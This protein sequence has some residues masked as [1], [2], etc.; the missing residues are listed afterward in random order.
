MN[1]QPNIAGQRRARIL[2]SKSGGGS[3]NLVV[4]DENANQKHVYAGG[5]SVSTSCILTFDAEKQAFILDAV[6]SEF[7]FNI[8]SAPGN[9]SAKELATAHPQLQT[10]ELEVTSSDDELL[11]DEQFSE[12]D[13]DNPY[14]YRHHLKR[15]LSSPDPLDSLDMLDSEPA[16]SS[17]IRPSTRPSP[18]HEHRPSKSRSQRMD[19]SPPQDETDADNEDSSDDGSLEIVMDGA[20]PSNFQGRYTAFGS[21]GNSGSPIGKDAPRDSDESDE[22]EM[23]EATLSGSDKKPEPAEHEAE[24]DD[25]GFSAMAEAIEA[26]L[27][28]QQQENDRE[29]GSVQD[30]VLDQ[31][32]VQQVESSSESEEE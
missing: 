14:D 30:E 5:Q 26:E 28:R 13:P 21:R 19:P 25:D 24:E 23:E 16:Q 17:P 6:N 1:V 10:G 15:H 31:G 18:V 22:D 9:G 32:Q 8:R 20:K 11:K 3:C 2:A 27:A 7:K 29:N 12:G 4:T